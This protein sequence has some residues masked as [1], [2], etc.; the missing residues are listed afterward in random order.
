MSNYHFSRTL[1][2]FYLFYI[3]WDQSSQMFCFVSMNSFTTSLTKTALW[4]SPQGCVQSSCF[5][6]VVFFLYMLQIYFYVDYFV[7]YIST[8]CAEFNSFANLAVWDLMSKWHHF[9][10]VDKNE[11]QRSLC[12]V[13]QISLVLL[14]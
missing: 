12:L 14:N 4:C 10:K 11:W 9:R 7:L 13:T 8:K 1:L 6:V 5:V 3:T 2:G